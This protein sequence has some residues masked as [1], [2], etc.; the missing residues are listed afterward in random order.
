M[1]CSV[2]TCVVLLF[3]IGVVSVQAGQVLAEDPAAT[4]LNVSFVR[5]IVPILTK[6]GC[7]AG[8]CHAKAGGGPNGFQ[9]S[10]LGFEPAED[11]E[12]L[13]LEGNGRRIFPAAIEH[14]L[15]LRKATGQVSHV[16]GVRIEAGSPNYLKIAQWIE[17]GMPYQQPNEP[18]LERMEVIPAKMMLQPNAQVQLQALAHYSDGTSRDVTSLALYESNAVAMLQVDPSGAVVA[19][20]L[21]GRAAVMV[22]FQGKTAVMS[23]SIP[24]GAELGVFPANRNFIDEHVFNN[25]RELGLPPSPICDD[26]TFLRR[27]TLDIAGRLPSEREATEFL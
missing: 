10:L 2:K 17:Q 21:P 18:E 23:A 22:R 27:V 15:I 3:T 1:M 12:N 8:P 4:P 19:S 24:L 25:L 26:G 13:V 7:N 11:Y 5:D 20:D 6:S 16:G 9:L 14:S